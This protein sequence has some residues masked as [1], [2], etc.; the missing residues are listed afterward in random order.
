MF[1]HL[2]NSVR[3][4]NLA[5]ATAT[6]GRGRQ[7]ATYHTRLATFYHNVLR[8][9][10]MILGY[11]HPI[12]KEDAAPNPVA[13]VISEIKGTPP[14]PKR[15][16]SPRRP[17]KPEVP[18]P[19]PHNQPFIKS[20]TVHIRVRE[21]LANKHNLLS[22]IMALQCITGKR[23]EIVRSVNDAAPWK[24][25]KNMPIATKVC[26]EGDLMY[27]FLDKLI[28]IVLPRLKEWNGLTMRAGDGMGNVT[29]GFEPTALGLFPEIE[30]I[31]DMFPLITG[32][33]VSIYTSAVRNPTGR[34]LLSGFGLPFLHA[35]D[36]SKV[37]AKVKASP[38]E[39]D[40]CENSSST[41]AVAASDQQ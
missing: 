21:A 35:R 19:S 23:P 27:E 31:Y 1:S 33:D 26:L 13:E 24:L 40:N 3:A 30:P 37:K 5:R 2:Q 15:Q 14:N 10:L 34:L 16:H 38:A 41:A 22:A 28:E 20:V 11:E 9:D 29:L 25:R 6:A 7:V 32:F 8:D 4:I 39:A 36:P 18:A 12:P 17:K